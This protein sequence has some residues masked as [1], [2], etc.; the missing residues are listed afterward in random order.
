MPRTKSFALTMALL[1]M[2]AVACGAGPDAADEATQSSEQAVAD[3][4]ASAPSCSYGFT[5]DWLPAQPAG[6]RVSCSQNNVGLAG[7]AGVP[8]SGACRP[9]KAETG[10]WT[11]SA[12]L[13]GPVTGNWYE[14]MPTCAEVGLPSDCCFYSWTPYEGSTAPDHTALCAAMGS[15]KILEVGGCMTCWDPPGTP[16]GTCSLPQPGSIPCPTCGFHAQ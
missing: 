7:W 4:A 2:A 5:D 8:K 15:Q 11:A 13:D 3:P 12:A 16:V 6:F 9:I 10:F 1:G 14:I